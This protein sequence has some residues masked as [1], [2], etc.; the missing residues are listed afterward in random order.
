MNIQELTREQLIAQIKELSVK[1]DEHAKEQANPYAPTDE[2]YRFLFHKAPIGICITDLQGAI[3][4]VNK[5]TQEF[6]GY[7]EHEFDRMNIIDLYTIPDERKRLIDRIK[8]SKGIRDFEINIKKKDGSIST[9]LINSDLI[10]L[11][12]AEVLLTSIYDISQY[13]GM[14]EELTK[15]E[16]QYQLLFKNVPV[17][18]TVTNY[19]G[20]IIDSNQAIQELTGYTEKELQ[21]M[22]VLSFYMDKGERKRL[23]D[24]TEENGAVR[25]F[26]TTFRHKNGHAISVLINTDLI[27]YNEREKILLN[28]IRDITDIMKIEDESTKQRDFT[29]AILDT[30]ASLILVLDREG[31]IT[32]I[33]KECENVSGYTSEELQ[34]QYI[35]GSLSNE[36]EDAKKRVAELIAGDYPI[37]HENVWVKKD[38]DE[39]LISWSSTILLDNEH[40]AEYIISTGIDITERKLAEIELKEA[41]EKLAGWVKE[42]E[43]RTTEMKYISDMGEQLQSCQTVEE[44]SAISAQYIR[45]ICP[46]SHGAI[47]LI[48]PSKDQAEAVEM[49][50][51]PVS[52]EKLFVPANCWAIRRNRLHLVDE[53]HPGL[54]CGHIIGP[55]EGEYLCTPMMAQ[56]ET[57]G[58]LHLSRAV[59]C[60][61]SLGADNVKY[62]DHKIEI[63][64]EMADHIALALSNLKL[65]EALRQQSIRDILTGLFNRRY[66]EETLARELK[67]AARENSPVGVI[68]FDIDHFKNYNDLVGHDGGDALLRELG[69]FL[70]KN[71]RG[72]DI[73]C[74]YGGEEFVAVLPGADAKTTAIRAEELRKGVKELL[75]YHL[76]K[77]LGTCTIS[78]GVSAYPEHGQ[79]SETVLKSADMALYRAKNEGRDRVV[80]APSIG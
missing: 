67:R 26:A 55:K 20:K 63:I 3:L 74:R 48:N 32:R 53:T 5:A 29:N 64:L 40:N 21:K 8:E 49:W 42:L 37:K 56:G 38:G 73:I 35:W 79:T 58:I 18:I 4:V 30:T 70:L 47:Y 7:S 1:I 46:A 9:V 13:K 61:D 57:I 52:T 59:Y 15:T 24:A 19:L 34:G 14:R 12:D 25:D 78:L 50:G 23:L 45:M 71:T 17:G 6:L 33:N 43:E 60:Q 36:P 39:R 75:V 54:L 80:V 11:D 31:K 10:V 77:P 66:M 27:K 2:R 65:R 69:A 68:M 28:S 76:G 72:G 16:D 51:D 62:K 44:A 41:N 22:N